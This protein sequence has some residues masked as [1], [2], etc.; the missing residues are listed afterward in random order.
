MGMAIKVHI[1]ELRIFMEEKISV[2]LKSKKLLSGYLRGYDQFLNIVI[3]ID[4]SQ[5][6]ISNTSF[7]IIRGSS[8]ISIKKC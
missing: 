8:I 2:F 7:I 1:P 6:S 5:Q 4:N 3:E